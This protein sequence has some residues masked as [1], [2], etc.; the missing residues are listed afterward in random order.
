MNDELSPCCRS[1]LS[2]VRWIDPEVVEGCGIHEL[3]YKN[4]R[5]H[6][7][8]WRRGYLRRLFHSIRKACQIKI[9][10]CVR[11]P[12]TPRISFKGKGGRE[13][14]LKYCVYWAAMPNPSVSINTLFAGRPSPGIFPWC[15]RVLF[16]LYQTCI[17]CVLYSTECVY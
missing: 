11:S 17:E 4:G 15:L 2:C 8:E 14:G 13:G 10:F 3:I 5:Q 7:F 16:V 6:G 9:N 1:V 12:N